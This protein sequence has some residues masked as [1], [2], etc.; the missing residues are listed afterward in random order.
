MNGEE[1]MGIFR[2]I[3]SWLTMKRTY[4]LFV[5]RVSGDGVYGYV[6]CYGKKWMAGFVRW[7]FRAA[8]K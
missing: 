6:D 3:R 4:R 8:K 5:D 7:G 1:L 2:W